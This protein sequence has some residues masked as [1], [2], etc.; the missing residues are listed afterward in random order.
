MLLSASVAVTVVTA[1]SFSS[2]L[3][4]AVS[5]ASLL[6]ISGAVFSI[7]FCTLTV[8]VC[9]SVKVASPSSVA[10]ISTI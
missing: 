8:I 1:V 5:P 4:V 9:R 2:T 7:T 6:V 3:I 10:V